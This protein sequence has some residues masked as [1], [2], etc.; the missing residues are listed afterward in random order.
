MQPNDIYKEYG[1][2]VLSEWFHHDNFYHIPNA[3]IDLVHQVHGEIGFGSR[4][5]TSCIGTNVYN[6]KRQTK[7]AIGNPL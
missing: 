7:A 2:V 4:S 1:A 5:S 6:G 3:V